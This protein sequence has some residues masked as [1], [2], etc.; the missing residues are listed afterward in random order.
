MN[1]SKTNQYDRIIEIYMKKIIRYSKKN[2]K[3]MAQKQS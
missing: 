3:K 2:E 1:I